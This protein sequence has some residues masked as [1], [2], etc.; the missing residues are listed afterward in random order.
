[1]IKQ[2]KAKKS[3][4]I[5][6]LFSA[7]TF[8][9][10]QGF[11]LTDDFSSLENKE[12]VTEVA[13]KADDLLDI[14]DRIV[15]ALNPYS[16]ANRASEILKKGQ[17][18]GLFGLLDNFLKVQVVLLRDVYNELDALEEVM[19]QH[20][21]KLEGQGAAAE[22]AY[23]YYKDLYDK[24]RIYKAKLKKE[25]FALASQ[26]D[27]IDKAFNKVTDKLEIY[28]PLELVALIFV[29]NYREKAIDYY[30]QIVDEI[31]DI[32]EEDEEERNDE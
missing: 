21:D 14:F 2:K 31:Q 8:L 26:V 17:Y 23:K 24:I 25:S 3:L 10:C 5:F 12:R 19:K 27:K 6:I 4:L 22:V 32:F 29:N 18:K 30:S 7:V 28:K 15:L 11:E 9:G 13:G 1:M 16:I 20:M